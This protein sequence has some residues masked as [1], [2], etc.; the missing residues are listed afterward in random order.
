MRNAAIAE[1]TELARRDR[2]VMLLTADL[3]FG[4][5][6]DFARELPDQF[7]NM[8]V[9]EQ[10]MIG[11]ATGMAEAGLRPYCYTIATFAMLR[12]FEF[13]R[14]GP[15]AH[16]LPVGI[17]GVGAGADYSHDGLTHYA[18]EDL[19]LARSQPGMTVY[20]PVSDE[21]TRALIRE[22]YELPGVAYY[23][24]SRKGSPAPSVDVRDE[25]PQ[26]ADVVVF[27]V[28]TARQRALQIAQAITGLG[29]STRV[30]S[31]LRLDD[32]TSDDLA[33]HLSQ[34]RACLT[35][36]DHYDK[37][38]LGSAVAETIATRGIGV[39][40]VMDA[41][42]TLPVGAI[43]SAEYLDA[44]LHRPVEELAQQAVDVLKLRSPE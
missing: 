22:G 36:E 33:R 21:D 14:N 32:R 23:R 24:L 35:V 38:G 42:T 13:I 2:R 12:P 26:Q 10:A 17:I 25:D 18:M 30:L 11:V 6:D 40:L 15:V 20:C 4:V 28:G 37:G 41:V 43:G 5:L 9:T 31:V 27:A 7:V 3:G 44:K 1:L 19:A 39:P 8:G 16:R 29:H 34:A